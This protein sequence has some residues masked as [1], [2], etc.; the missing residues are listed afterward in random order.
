MKT[1]H[2]Y[3][4]FNIKTTILNAALAFVA[5]LLWS[6]GSAH[7]ITRTLSVPMTMRPLSAAEL[8]AGGAYGNVL[9]SPVN[10]TFSEPNPNED[11]MDPS[12]DVWGG[13]LVNAY[14]AS[15]NL[16]PCVANVSFSLGG[17]LTYRYTGTDTSPLN[18]PSDTPEL[19]GVVYKD[20]VSPTTGIAAVLWVADPVLY[21]PGP[22]AVGNN[23]IATG[24]P[25]TLTQA[26]LANG[27]VV[28][29]KM[30]VF[31]NIAQLGAQ[32]SWSYSGLPILNISYDDASCPPNA[33]PTI[34]AVGTTISTL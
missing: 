15:Y 11:N 31:D 22:P 21:N 12:D 1:K 9:S 7:A 16:P 24:T 17:D 4:F 33:A 29:A 19:V 18:F 20:V 23:P 14:D 5:L 32:F 8:S 34:S 13:S 10:D 2:N 6:G 26:E 27:I 28:A 30:E 3:R 25:Y